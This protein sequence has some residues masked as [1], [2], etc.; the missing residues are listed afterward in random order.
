M[1]STYERWMLFITSARYPWNGGM[2][3][4]PRI[5]MIRN[6]EPWLVYFPSPATESEKMQGHITEQNSPP[7]MN[8][9]IG[10][11]VMDTAAACR[12]YNVLLAEG[13]PHA[14]S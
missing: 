11:E 3:A 6:V 14:S 5:I 7:L 13:R 2:S 12:T 9:K 8:A 1:V 4:P 10:Y